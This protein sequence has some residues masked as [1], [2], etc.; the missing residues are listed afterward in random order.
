MEEKAYAFSSIAQMALDS[1]GSGSYDR[2]CYAITPQTCSD[3]FAV[4]TFK[5]FEAHD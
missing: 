2:T 4:A 3:A 5:P 1:N